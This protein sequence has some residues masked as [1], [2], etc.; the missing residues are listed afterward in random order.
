MKARVRNNPA[1]KVLC[2]AIAEEVKPGLS[3]A[4]QEL[5]IEEVQI[6]S[7]ALDQS[8]GYLAGFPGFEERK[9]GVGTAP[10][11]QSVICMCG[12]SHARMNLLLRSLK[13][14]EINIPLKAIVTPTNQTWSFAK[15]IAE[16]AR[17]HK[18]LEGRRKKESV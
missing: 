16:L 12:I 18:A 13:E 14:Q 3:K 15:L 5:S 2:F 11:S 9:G 6:P 8:V 1:E 10:A 7:D 17:E 4:L